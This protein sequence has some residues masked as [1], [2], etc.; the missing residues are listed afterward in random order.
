MGKATSF[1]AYIALV[2]AAEKKLLGIGMNDP[3]ERL[4]TLRGVYYGTTWS[5]DWD[6]ES[7][8]SV[9]GATVRNVGFL[10]YLAGNS[11]RDPRPAFANSTLLAD[12]KASQSMKDAGRNVDMGHLLIGLE[13]RTTVARATNFPGEGGTGL[14]IVTWLGDL[15]GGAANLARRR[16]KTPNLSAQYVFDNPASDYGVSDNLEGDI[17]GY[18]AGS[19]T[20]GDVPAISGTIAGVIKSYVS[21]AQGGLWNGRAASFA[22]GIGAQLDSKGAIANATALTATLATK[23][24]DFGIWY[25]STRWVPTG[26]LMGKDAELTCQHMKGAAEEV[27]TI[28]VKTVG[29]AIAAAPARVGAKK[30]FPP[31]TTPGRCQSRL[32]GAASSIKLP[33]LPTLHF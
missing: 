7:K 23:L 2:D 22:R 13:C 10:T 15:G 8:R 28:F 17:A 32:L 3:I 24:Y 4:K 11:P 20:G 6:V 26:E 25:A 29:E 1:A 14:E 27:A 12:L 18:V 5:L 30:P 16:A 9:P 19:I 21:T 33:E 31:P